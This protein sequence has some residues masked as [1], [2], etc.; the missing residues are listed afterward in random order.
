MVRAAPVWAQIV[1][2]LIWEHGMGRPITLVTGASRGI[3]AAIVDDLNAQGHHVIGMSRSKPEA[4]KGLFVE[5]DLADAAAI[6]SALDHVL[7]QYAVTR[8]VNNAG[9]ALVSDLAETSADDFDR[10]MNLN[11]RAPVLAIQAVLPIMRSAKFGRIVTIGSR[12]A[13]GKQTRAVYGATKAAVLSLTR[14]V[15]MENASY[16]ITANCVAPGPIETDMLLANYPE[17]SAQLAAFRNQMPMARMGQPS[18][19]AYACSYFLN[20]RAGFTTGQVLYVCGG[21]SLGIV[22]L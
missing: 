15:A 17:G 16:G 10:M 19:I 13:L 4:F 9:I 6:S 20:D 11:V 18:E 2:Q 8:L 7:K 3:G 12:A 1:A 22:P 21:M 5:V 14:T